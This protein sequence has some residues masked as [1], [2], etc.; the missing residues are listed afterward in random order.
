ML[1]MNRLP[2]SMDP[3]YADFEATAAYRRGMELHE[4]RHE[5]IIPADFHKHI[6]RLV[7]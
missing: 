3:C 4:A 1:T 2:A 5:E 7:S 6:E